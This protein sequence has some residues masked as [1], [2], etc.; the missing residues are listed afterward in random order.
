MNQSQNPSLI[1]QW[2][3]K[4][5][6]RR[7]FLPSLGAILLLSGI[8]LLSILGIVIPLPTTTLG[9]TTKT[10]QRQSTELLP[11]RNVDESAIAPLRVLVR[12]G[13]ND[14]DSTML[15]QTSL[16]ETTPVASTEQ[17]SSLLVVTATAEAVAA[18]NVAR[19]ETTHDTTAS[20]HS[21]YEDTLNILVL[22]SDL[23]TS[24]SNWRTDVIMIVAL[25]IR[26]NRGAILSIPRDVYIG[27]IPNHAPNRIN[28]I[29]YLGEQ[30]V[31][32]GGG[33]ALLKRLINEH[34]QI[35]IDHFLRFEFESFKEIVDAL[36]G[37]EITV[38]CAY[39]DDFFGADV[40]L[41]LEE[42][43]VRL[44]G[45]EALVYVRSRRLGGDLDRVRRQQRLVWA[46]R[47]QI[48]NENLL[49]RIPMLYRTFAD[50]VQTDIGIVN[51]LRLVRFTIALEEEDIYG[52]VLR[53]PTMIHP[54]WRSGMS[55]YLPDWP[56]IRAEAQTIFEQEPFVE[57][58][59]PAYCP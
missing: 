24:A 16:T 4:S 54:A 35:R 6:W 45:A 27:H 53:P 37:V 42:G 32:N 43:V 52:L 46:I 2:S 33:P 5:R 21:I 19:G 18:G 8:G 1:A 51:A 17:I 20:S 15:P 44:S 36:N 26:N 39:T 40:G 10:T 50:S 28:V 41:N 25:D 56:T 14:S 58:N 23:R 12:D 11:H 9:A 48:V 49:P 31:P 47:N 55:V 38:D 34:L 30:D 59:T 22:G 3:Q 29:D 13:D 57:T 7:Y